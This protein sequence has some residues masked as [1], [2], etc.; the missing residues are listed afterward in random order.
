MMRYRSIRLLPD[1]CGAEFTVQTG[2]IKT[3]GYPYRYP[4]KANC[5]W[6]I[7]GSRGFRTKIEFLDF[8]IEFS[9]NCLYDYLEIEEYNTGQSV[10]KRIGRF[11]G[12]NSPPDIV[13]SSY[14][15]ILLKFVSDATVRKKGVHL[16]FSK[17]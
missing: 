7:R 6:K 12:Y 16:R 1:I 5:V 11:C 17:F 3:P 14:N 8:K 4:S 10:A 13:I 9:R 2:Y 15:D